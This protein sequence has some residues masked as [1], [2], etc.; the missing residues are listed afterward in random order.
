MS[1]IRATSALCFGTSF[2]NQDDK[3]SPAGLLGGGNGLRA[4]FSISFSLKSWK[5]NPH[6]T[7]YKAELPH[8]QGALSPGKNEMILSKKLV[9]PV[10]VKY[11][12]QLI[13][14]GGSLPPL[15]CPR[16]LQ[17]IHIYFISKPPAALQC[18]LKSGLI[19]HPLSLLY[20]QIPFS[21]GGFS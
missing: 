14:K 11:H 15:Q 16:P 10:L 13:E 21:R 17:D 6:Q 7:L 5:Y 1:C 12:V 3:W 19:P 9:D 4:C 18:P 8:S 2:W 20:Y